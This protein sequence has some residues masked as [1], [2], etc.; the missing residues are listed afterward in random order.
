MLAEFCVERPP[1]GSGMSWGV[2]ST[3]GSSSS[4]R[5]VPTGGAA[6]RDAVAPDRCGVVIGSRVSGEQGLSLSKMYHQALPTGL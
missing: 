1:P 2:M 3:Y 4:S 5:S 6:G